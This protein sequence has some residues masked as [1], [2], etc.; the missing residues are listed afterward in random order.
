MITTVAV[1]TEL[2]LYQELLAAMLGSRLG[3]AVIG[4]AA[5]ELEATTTLNGT[6]PDIVILDASLPGAWNVARAA[7]DASVK[8]VMFGAT[9][10]GHLLDDDDADCDAV[11]AAAATTRT[12]LQTLELLA[13]EVDLTDQPFRMEAIA[14]LTARELEVLRLIARGLSNKE[15]ARQLT[16]SLATVKSHVHNVLYKLGM[17]RRVDA[18]RLLLL[19]AWNDAIEPAPRMSSG[20]QP[21]DWRDRIIQPTALDPGAAGHPLVPGAKE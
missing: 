15:I 1:F 21:A 6:L 16:V 20:L 14:T 13:R 4:V 2:R 18:G 9:D 8:V 7:Q 3:F 19:S 12:V 10:S 5:S 17:H 11:I